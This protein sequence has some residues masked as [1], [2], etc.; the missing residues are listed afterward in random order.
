MI[1]VATVDCFTMICPVVNRVR[2]FVYFRKN[3]RMMFQIKAISSVIIAK[4]VVTPM[5]S[6][7]L[8]A[9]VRPKF[10]SITTASMAH[11]C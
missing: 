6:S 10:G 9:A 8:C 1:Q 4:E 7:A 2:T 11:F 5:L 3:T